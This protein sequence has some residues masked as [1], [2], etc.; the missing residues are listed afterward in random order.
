MPKDTKK[1]IKEFIRYVEKLEAEEDN[2]GNGFDK[3]YQ[4]IQETQ[5][6][7][8]KDNIFTMDIGK[9]EANLKKNRYKDIL[10]YDEHRVVLSTM[11]GEVDSDYINASRLIGVKGTGGYIATQGPLASTVNDFWRMIWEYKV[12]IIFMACRIVELGK[13]KC[14][15]YWNDLGKSDVFGDITVFTEDEQEIAS[16]FIQRK[17]SVSR[18]EE[19]RIVIQFHYSG[20]PDHGIPD[21]PAHI[22]DLIGIMRRTRQNDELPLLIHCSAGCGRTGAIAA[23]DYVWTLLE[24]GRFDEDFNLYELICTFREQRM[25]IVQTAE[26]YALVNQVLKSLCQ[27]WLAKMASHT[28]EN[29]EL[30]PEN[31]Y[32]NSTRELAPEKEEN[33][34]EDSVS[35]GNIIQDSNLPKENGNQGAVVSKPTVKPPSYE[36]NAF[37]ERVPSQKAPAPPPPA[38]S[39]SKPITPIH[40]TVIQVG[41]PHHAGGTAQIIYKTQPKQSSKLTEVATS[42]DIYATVCKQPL[43]SSKSCE[44][45][46]T[47][48]KPPVAT[49]SKPPIVTRATVNNPPIN[50][51]LKMETHTNPNKPLLPIK[52]NLNI[53]ATVN[54]QESKA[55][56]DHSVKDSPSSIVHAANSR[57]TGSLRYSSGYSEVDNPFSFHGASSRGSQRNSSGYSEVDNASSIVFGA[58]SQRQFFESRASSSSSIDP[59]YDDVFVSN[60]KTSTNL[61]TSP[62][63]CQARLLRLPRVKGPVPMPQ[64]WKVK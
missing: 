37:K 8:R 20:W 35:L 33:V 34:Y 42:G 46:A 11:D 24:E 61:S 31:N 6:Q 53:Y 1:C 2:D 56:P 32:M 14:K 23:I 52:P 26:Q 48:N 54:K 47:V 28:Y 64:S 18:G 36:T 44:T 63:G 39:E 4:R 3:E 38:S 22:R 49:P 16:D 10:P 58:G 45:Y 7:R 57:S 29:V 17:L 50:N 59:A 40:S 9:T 41:S 60:T 21:D 55:P 12:E 51:K 62:P 15:Q 13:I 25:S 27:E 19:Q 43:T 30:E 5:I